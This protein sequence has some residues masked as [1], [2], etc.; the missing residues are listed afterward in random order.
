MPMIQRKVPETLAPAREIFLFY[1]GLG[2]QKY[3]RVPMYRYQNGFAY[4]ISCNDLWEPKISYYIE[5]H[6]EDDQVVGVIANSNQPVEVPVV[7]KR[8][9][10]P[11]ALP[12][13]ARPPH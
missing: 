7:A 13:G 11:A 8:S 10:A 4:Q 2:M 9:H 3:K 6:G 1:K 5:A 12:G